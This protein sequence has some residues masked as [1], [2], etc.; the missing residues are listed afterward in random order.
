MDFDVAAHT[1]FLATHGSH[2]YGTSLPESDVDVR[3]FAVA[4]K[5]V[6][7]GFAQGF[8][9][10]V[11]SVPNDSIVY[12]VQKFCKLAAD[13][14]PNVIEVLFVDE[15]NVLKITRS[16][17]LL[18]DHRDLFLSKKARHTFAGYAVA[19]LKRIKTHR[20]WLLSPP[21]HKPER[22][23]F[24]L[25]SMKITPD[26]MGA[27]DKLLSTET[28]G[29]EIEID[30]NVMQYVQLEKQFRSATQHWNQYVAWKA[31]RN[32]K[33]AVLEAQFGYD[34]KHAM[35]LVRL[36][37]MCL[38]LLAGKGVKV[39]RPDAEELLAIRRGVWSYDQLIE[40]AERGHEEI[41]RLYAT[42]T[43]PDHPDM[44][45]LNALCVEAQEIFW[46]EQ[47]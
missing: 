4:P 22:A 25:G 39:K 9:Q 37:R 6:V 11:S 44:E 29:D 1:V 43:L 18:R 34:T 23:E 15:S 7:L 17:S 20:K 19:Q 10:Q 38:E 26:M 31:S 14:N 5:E 3:G 40:Q 2:A 8:E 30:P 36:L 16:G 13:C 27:F 12:N 47:A 42:S 33:R 28:E 45:K 41:D 32:E 35:H 21:D 46:S 24:G